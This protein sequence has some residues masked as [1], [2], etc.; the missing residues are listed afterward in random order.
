VFVRLLL[1]RYPQKISNTID[2]L[3][4]LFQDGAILNNITLDT[5]LSGGI[6]FFYALAEQ[7]SQPY[8]TQGSSM[9]SVQL[10][11]RTEMGA[12]PFDGYLQPYSAASYLDPQ[13]LSQ[14]TA[15]DLGSQ[16]RPLFSHGSGLFSQPQPHNLHSLHLLCSP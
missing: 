16:P 2:P 14:L 13:V 6:R 15:L 7:Y 11:L 5:G 9:L 8:D 12:A 1:Q 3:S 10:S 4:L